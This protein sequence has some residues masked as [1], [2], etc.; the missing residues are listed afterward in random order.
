MQCGKKYSFNYF[1]PMC[2]WMNTFGQSE[3]WMNEYSVNIQWIFMNTLLWL[4]R[5]HIFPFRSRDLSAWNL[6]EVPR[7]PPKRPRERAPG[8]GAPQLSAGN[9]PAAPR[10]PQNGPWSTPGT[11]IRATVCTLIYPFRSNAL[12]SAH[13]STTS[14]QQRITNYITSPKPLERP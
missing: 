4:V 1:E 11:P 9:L 3:A 13:Q 5:V 6:L 10:S 14:L 2:E 12:S 8:R 7:T